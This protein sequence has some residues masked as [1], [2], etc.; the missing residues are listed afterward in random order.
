MAW[1]DVLTAAATRLTVSDD[2]HWSLRPNHLLIARV[3]QALCAQEFHEYNFGG[4]PASAEGLIQFKESWGTERRPVLEVR[5]RS[6]LHRL[7]RG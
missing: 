1:K 4:S 5:K 2:R 6:L 3:I 7:I